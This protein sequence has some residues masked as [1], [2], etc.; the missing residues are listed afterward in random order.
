[1]ALNLPLPRQILAHAHWTL[2][3][4]KMS[5]SL[6]N[7]VNPFFA[8]QRFGVDAMRYFLALNGG[9]KDDAIYDNTLVIER[10]KSGLQGTLGNLLSRVTRGKGWNVRRAIEQ[11]EKPFDSSATDLTRSLEILPRTVLWMIEEQLDVGIALGT[12]MKTIKEVCATT[13]SIYNPV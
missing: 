7:V 11:H 4:E 3:R 10:Y 2:G 13:L 12:I 6:G 9:I 5:K 1:M 8:I